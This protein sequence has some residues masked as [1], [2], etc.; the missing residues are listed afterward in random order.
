[1]FS[2]CVSVR[3]GSTLEFIID[4]SADSQPAASEKSRRTVLF[5]ITGMLSWADWYPLFDASKG[6]GPLPAATA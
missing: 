6:C 3:P 2:V 4:W 1:M 5:G